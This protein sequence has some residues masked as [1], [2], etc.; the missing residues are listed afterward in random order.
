MFKVCRMNLKLYNFE[1]ECGF[2]SLI[3]FIVSMY[4]TMAWNPAEVEYFTLIGN[5]HCN[6][7]C[8]VYPGCMDD[9]YS[10]N[11]PP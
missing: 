1:V 11:R 6:N 4:T 7:N 8:T 2:C 10:L 5:I 3:C 9:Q